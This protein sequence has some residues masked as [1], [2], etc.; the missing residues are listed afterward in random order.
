MRNLADKPWPR[1]LHE[2][3]AAHYLGVGKTEFRELVANGTFP[4]AILIGTRKVYD[5]AK[6]DIAF[7]EMGSNDTNWFENLRMNDET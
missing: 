6:L 5:R 7:E 4:R 1:G 3:E 2:D